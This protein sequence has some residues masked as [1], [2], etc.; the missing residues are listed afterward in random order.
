MKNY[1]VIIIGGSFA[2]LSAAMALG[3]SLRKTLIIDGGEPCN[4]FTPEAHNFITHDG[5]KPSEISAMAKE[6][7]LAY[8]SIKFEKGFAHKVEKKKDFFTVEV[9]NGE[10]YTAKKIILATGVKDQLLDINGF[11]ECWGKT[12]IHCPYCHGYEFKNEKTAILANTDDAYH[13]AGL[14]KNLTNELKILTNG[15]QNFTE[16]QLKKFEKNNIEIIQEPIIK[17]S[18]TEGNLEKVIF[19]NQEELTLKALYARIPFIQSSSI[20]EDLGCAFTEMGHIQVNFMQETSIDGVYAAGDNTIMLRSIANAVNA[21]N[22]AGA[23]VNMKLVEE[24]F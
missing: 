7:V 8:S 17:F 22:V 20:A 21:G 1:E 10:N 2:G 15:H 14:V 13:L 11:K 16:D 23:I 6:Q 5:K 24:E 18:Q 9:D 19:T 4:R 12:I 3:R